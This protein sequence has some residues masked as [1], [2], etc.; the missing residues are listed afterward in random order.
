MLVVVVEASASMAFYHKLL[1]P[2]LQNI[3]T[4]NSLLV[5]AGKKPK[6]LEF[7]SEALAKVPLING[8]RRFDVNGIVKYCKRLEQYHA[9]VEII[10][11]LCSKPLEVISDHSMVSIICPFF[12]EEF[13]ILG[14]KSIKSE[15]CLLLQKEVTYRE[16]SAMSDKLV[17]SP[18]SL[19]SPNDFIQSQTPQQSTAP[20]ESDHLPK[21]QR[22]STKKSSTNDMVDNMNLNQQL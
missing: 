19:H 14:L 2:V 7:S 12:Y 11:V 5:Y 10:I 9:S 20:F 3:V 22:L 16:K 8:N 17:K 21:K 6:L 13:E 18:L 15:I 1:F 4:T